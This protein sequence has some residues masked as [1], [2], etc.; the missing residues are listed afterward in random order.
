M[1]VFRAHRRAA[2]LTVVAVAMLSAP[3][4]AV[5]PA[6]AAHGPSAQAEVGDR[7]REALRLLAQPPFP[8]T[9]LSLLNTLS[10]PEGPPMQPAPPREITQRDLVHQLRATLRLRSHHAVEEGLAVFHSSQI[11][12]VVPDPNLRA[13][14]ASLA[15][16]PAQASVPSS[17]AGATLL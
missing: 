12:T 6:A 4:A 17:P 16:S 5:T 11:A 9:D 2:A 14:L 13:A 15:G 8:P 10:Y 7:G 1:T 3:L